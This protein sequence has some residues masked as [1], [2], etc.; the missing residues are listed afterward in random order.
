[1]TTESE[2]SGA[3][4]TRFSA[5]RHVEETGST[6]ADL[7]ALAST[8]QAVPPG[9]P[10]PVLVADHQSAGRGRQRRRWHGERANTLLLSALTWPPPQWAGLT[11]LLA[12]VALVEALDQVLGSGSRPGDVALKWPNDV[13]APGHG[14]RKLAGIL[15]EATTAPA[16]LAAVVGIGLNL[17][18]ASTPPAEVAERAVTLETIAGAPIDRWA[19]VRVLLGALD[20]WLGRVEV[21]GAAPLLAAYRDRCLTLGR[22]VRF[23]T[24]REVVTG[25]A[26]AVTDEGALVVATADGPVSLTAGDAHHV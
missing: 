5:V 22:P 26:E 25:R 24:A 1:M 14:E 9:S 18:W 23:E 20:R 13:L 19:V 2:P 15:V 8:M 3:E 21:D 12:G 16:G 17:R 11:P 10:L 7:L 4:G 6:N